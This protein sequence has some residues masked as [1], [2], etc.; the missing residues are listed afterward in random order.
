M[1][2]Q[3]A[4]TGVL[5]MAYGSPDTLED[6]EQYY[7][8]VRGGRIPTPE[9]VAHLAERYAAVG[10]HTPLTALTR[11]VA[12]KLQAALD[13]RAPGRFK[14]YIGMKYWT[15]FINDTVAQMAADGVRE[16][17]A[18]ALAPHYSKISI[19][20][21][22]KKVEQANAE[23]AEPI[24]V[25]MVESFQGHPLFRELIGRRIRAGLEQ[26]PAAERDEVTVLFS[27]HS[28]PERVLAWGDPYPEELRA[29]AAGI[30]EQLGL[31]NW[32]QCY[33]SAGSTGEPW[34]G[35]DIAEAL[36]R[37]AAEG[38]RNVLSVPFGF[39]SDHLEILYD[40]DIECQAQARE[41]GVTLK[42]I[43]L[44]NDDDEFVALLAAL[45]TEAQAAR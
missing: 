8:N 3:T 18:I 42:R 38:K 26:F 31:R 35:P 29:S 43:S 12:D 20:G 30:A 24:A 22:L 44:P 45:A 39:V 28:L 36:G 14:T 16:M 4:P 27:A 15:P 9:Q 25:Q 37:L 23:L 11:S 32:A 41:L 33:Q 1:P 17:I 19:G 21:Y 40:L 34:L 10:G 13:A 7:V 6:V 2:D 5:L